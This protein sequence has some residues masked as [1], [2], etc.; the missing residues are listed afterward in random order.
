MRVIGGAHHTEPDRQRV[1][2]PINLIQ[3]YYEEVGEQYNL[4][5]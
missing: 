4:L 5:Q 3:Q 2:S 1:N